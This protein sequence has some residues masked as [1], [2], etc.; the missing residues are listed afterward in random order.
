M[1]IALT[2]HEIYQDADYNPSCFDFDEKTAR[3]KKLWRDKRP[4]PT[5]AELQTKW[6]SIKARIFKQ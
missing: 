1:D 6:A 2:M 5:E 3:E 4:M